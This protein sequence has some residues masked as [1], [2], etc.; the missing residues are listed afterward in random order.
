MEWLNSNALR[1]YPLREDCS[2]IPVDSNGNALRGVT[3]PNYVIVDFV[4]TTAMDTPVRVYLKQLIAVGTL[5]TFS[6]YDA[7]DA[8]IALVSVNTSTHV[9]GTGYIVSG[10]GTYDDA[11]GRLVI[12]DLQSIQQ[13]LPEGVYTFTLDATEFEPT[14]VRP[15]LRGVRSLQV[16]S[17]GSESSYIYGNVQLIAGDN[18]KLTY[19]AGANSIRIDA[20]S[21]VGLDEECTCTPGPGQ[22]IVVKTI[23][24]KAIEDV[25]IEGDGNCISVDTSDSGTITITD[26]CSKP[27]CG[28]PELEFITNS[29][30]V[31]DVSVVNLQQYSLALSERINNFV[32]NFILTIK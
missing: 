21:S 25:V 23:N 7:S 24:G 16:V 11:R 2:R 26:K 29:L 32:T 27:C 8:E 22:N 12:G 13:D 20:T 6:F 18:V 28:C 19:D 10:V 1:A 5:L 30:K 31:L 3:L 9:P 4:L 15:D 17:Q 14:T